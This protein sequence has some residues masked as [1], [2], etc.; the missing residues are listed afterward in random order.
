M[1]KNELKYYSSLQKK[2]YRKAE[3]KFLVEGAKLIR[4]AIDS[5][6]RCEIVFYTNQFEEKFGEFQDYLKSKG[7]KSE[8]ISQKELEKLSDT[9]S[10]QGIIG[11][12]NEKT[13]FLSH[14]NPK[15][16]LALEDISDPGNMGAIIRNADW[17]GLKKIIANKDCAEIY[18]PKVIRASAGSVFHLEIL[19][20]DDFYEFLL[21]LKQ[22][23][24]S[25]LTAD[26][27]GESVYEYT[28]GDKIILTL[29]N[30]AKGPSDKLKSITDNSITIP[31][32][33]KAESLNVAAASAVLI[34]ELARKI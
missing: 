4:E 13:D 15:F 27:N 17:F 8:L 9:E 20:S 6:F 2:K 30:E 7:C 11:I 23:G 29:S 34:S 28:P 18:N 19:Y 26:L 31:G 22:E 12:F 14:S 25:I 10:P 3:K 16:L 5:E 33:G 32:H 21:R 24:H 1:T